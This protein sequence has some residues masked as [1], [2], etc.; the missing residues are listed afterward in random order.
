QLIPV[1]IV[2]PL[3]FRGQVEFG[4]LTQSTIAFEH[5]LGAVSLV[6]TQFG[7]LSSFAS[8]VTR[9]GALERAFEAAKCPRP[10]AIEIVDDR[11][12]LVYEGVTLRSVLRDH[13]LV[14]N[15]SMSVFQGM[16]ILVTGPNEAARLAVFRSA[17]GLWRAG[18]GRI[19]RPPNGGIG[20]M[21][22]R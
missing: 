9:L 21:P 14:D 18:Q 22:Q 2:C 20:F 8:V 7:A 5:L 4:V 16:R 10:P 15:L 19:R 13:P 6:I 1:L 17:A 11:D 12:R 3:Y